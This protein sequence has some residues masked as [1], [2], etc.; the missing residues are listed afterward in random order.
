MFSGMQGGMGR[1]DK[2][3]RDENFWDMWKYTFCSNFTTKAMP[4]IVFYI[5]T[6]VYIIS[7]FWSMINYGYLN[8]S[9]FLG[10]SLQL[11]DNWGAKNPYKMMYQY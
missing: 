9:V 3:P 10:P 5:S 8:N 6:A 7:V 1:Q 11:L 2:P 4:A